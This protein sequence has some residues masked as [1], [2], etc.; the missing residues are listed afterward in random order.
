MLTITLV[1][2]NGSGN[3]QEFLYLSVNNLIRYN[4]WKVYPICSLSIISSVV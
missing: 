2:R 1:M 3:K 4:V